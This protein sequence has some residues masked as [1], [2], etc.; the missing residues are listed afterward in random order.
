MYNNE[1]FNL[2]A[3]LCAAKIRVVFHPFPRGFIDVDQPKMCMSPPLPLASPRNNNRADSHT[4]T[5]CVLDNNGKSSYSIKA[6]RVEEGVCLSALAKCSAK[7]ED[8]VLLSTFFHVDDSV[9]PVSCVSS[10]SQ[11][12]RHTHWSTVYEWPTL[13]G[14]WKLSLYFSLSLPFLFLQEAAKCFV[15]GYAG[16]LGVDQESQCKK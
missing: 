1:P 12:C 2:T 11:S 3:G 6:Q 8:N 5:H 16:E 4:L 9:G 15:I 7:E 14:V 13:G 10:D